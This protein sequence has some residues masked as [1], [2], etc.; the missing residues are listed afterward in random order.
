MK[1]IDVYFLNYKKIDLHVHLRA[2]HTLATRRSAHGDIWRLLR[3]SQGPYGEN[4]IDT[5][6]LSSII[7]TI[8][9]STQHTP[10]LQT[11]PCWEPTPPTWWTEEAPALTPS[12]DP[13][14]P[15]THL[16]IVSS[17]GTRKVKLNIRGLTPGRRGEQGEMYE[18]M[19]TNPSRLTGLDRPNS[20]STQCH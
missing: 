5:S 15:H 10:C 3:T 20:G 7:A 9:S 16:Q 4:R 12:R 2:E 17:T 1:Q 6:R 19:T 13:G 11:A 18:R 14:R 8:T